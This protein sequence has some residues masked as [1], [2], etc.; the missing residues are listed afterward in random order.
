MSG[1]RFLGTVLFDPYASNTTGKSTICIYK[2]YKAF[3]NKNGLLYC[4]NSRLL[5]LTFTFY[6]SQFSIGI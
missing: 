5:I 2:T 6:S 4:F 1:C 3:L